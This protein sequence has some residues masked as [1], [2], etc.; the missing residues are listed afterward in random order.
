MMTV[1]IE[2]IMTICKHS[3]YIILHNVFILYYS[4]LRDAGKEDRV[5]NSHSSLHQDAVLAAN[6]YYLGKHLVVMGAVI[7]LIPSTWAGGGNWKKI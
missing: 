1:L 4:L 3:T 2:E 7:C 5:V 6:G